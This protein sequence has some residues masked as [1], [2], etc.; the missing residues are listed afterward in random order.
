MSDQFQPIV[1][2]QRYGR[3][4]VDFW[5]ST[6]GFILIL[7]L[8]GLM[9][10]FGWDYLKSIP[11]WVWASLVLTPIVWVPW[12]MARAKDDSHL[13]VVTDGPQRLT[14]YRVGKRVNLDIQGAGIPM[15]SKTGKRRTL[16]TQF[17]PSTGKGEGT[18]LAEFTQFEM[19][20]DLHTLDRLSQAFS[21]HLREERITQEL[22]AVEVERRV[23]SLSQ[24]WIGIAMATLEPDELESALDIQLEP[25]MM[26]IE[27]ELDVILDE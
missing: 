13:L 5:S 24:R 22:V 3:T 23:K 27:P 19:A 15:T 11:M 20:R 9:F 14:E 1:Y 26:P 2:E 10:Y 12:L 7:I 18:A 17:D 21:K 8:G 6:G 4:W 25:D 16:L